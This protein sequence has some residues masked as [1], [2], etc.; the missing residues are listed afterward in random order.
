V[1]LTVPDARRSYAHAFGLDEL[2]VVGLPVYGGRLP[3]NI[4]GF[5][6][7]LDGRGAPAVAVVLYGN[8][9][10][11]DALLEL[12]IRLEERGFRVVSGAAFIGEH[13]ISPKIATGRPDESDLALAHDFGRR[14]A[15][16][17]NAGGYG[18][19]TVKGS[20]PFVAKGTGPSYTPQTSDSCT[21][22]G[23]CAANC[24][25]GA[26][27]PTDYRTVDSA[28]CF[29]CARC[30]KDC[31]QGAKQFTDEGFLTRRSDMEKRLGAVRREPELFLPMP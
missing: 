30:V 8:R 17:A 5:F 19:L 9:E 10:Y 12:K 20:N 26:I 6:A 1:D 18:T 13:T 29:R 31:P 3:K 14:S 25:W 28:K 11:D 7:G 15:A 27:D 23:L 4:E 21:K 24:P 2:A 16:E 22:C